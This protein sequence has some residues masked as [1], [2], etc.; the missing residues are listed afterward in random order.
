MY[1]YTIVHGSITTG[2]DPVEKGGS[3]DFIVLVCPK[4]FVRLFCWWCYIGNGHDILLALIFYAMT[5][6]VSG[7]CVAPD[8]RPT[9]AGVGQQQPWQQQQQ[10]QRWLSTNELNT[11]LKELDAF[12][13]EI[14][15]LMFGP[16]EP[17]VSVDEPAKTRSQP[18]PRSLTVAEPE[19]SDIDGKAAATA[20]VVQTTKRT[21]M[22]TKRRPRPP[23]QQ[24]RQWRPSDLD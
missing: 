13:L 2:D 11:Q 23:R 9:S 10:Q 18:P 4:M 21:K 17:T 24:Q 12:L 3:S 16:T 5:E 19:C 7:E 15:Y 8:S 20:A 14:E 1:Y 22:V 6:R